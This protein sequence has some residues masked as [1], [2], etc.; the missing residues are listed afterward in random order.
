[1]ADLKDMYQEKAEEL[2]QEEY[3]TDF[4][5]LPEDTQMAVY[6]LAMGLVTDRLMDEA[7]L[8]RKEEGI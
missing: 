7:D 1:M 8:R 3:K 2:A 5:D 6:N 4:Y